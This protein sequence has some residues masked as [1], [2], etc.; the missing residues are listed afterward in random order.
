MGLRC[1]HLWMHLFAR[2]TGAMAFYSSVRA[3]LISQN[4]L[5]QQLSADALRTRTTLPLLSS[6]APNRA[7]SEVL[8]TF[9]SA[10]VRVPGGDKVAFGNED[11]VHL[12]ECLPQMTIYSVADFCAEIW[13]QSRR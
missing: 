11:I 9:D 10:S 4:Q 12:V 8:D 7:V 13:L 6:M 5:L 1:M 2:E 3:Q